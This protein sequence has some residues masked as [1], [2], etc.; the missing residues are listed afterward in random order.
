MEEV[1]RLINIRFILIAA[2]ILFTNAL[3]LIRDNYGQK[4]AAK[5]YDRLASLAQEYKSDDVTNR[6][7]VVM[8]YNQYKLENDITIENISEALQEARNLLIAEADYVDGYKGSVEKKIETSTKLIDA[9][10]YKRNSFENINILKTRYDM[11]KVKDINVTLSNGRWLDSLYDYSY[12]QIFSVILLSITV[13]GF[14]SE[15]KTGL[16]YIIHTGKNGRVRLFFKRFAII[17]VEALAVNII[18]YMEAVL[19][20]LNIYGGSGAINDLASSSE[21][22]FIVGGTYTRVQMAVI[23]MLVSTFTAIVLSLMLWLILSLFSNINIGMC[24]YVVLCA[25]FVIVHLL[26]STKSPV[27]FAHYLNLYYWFYPHKLIVY[28]NWGYSFGVTS[29]TASALVFTLVS[30]AVFLLINF[31]INTKKY[32]TGRANAVERTLELVMSG[33]MR[34]LVHAPQFLKEIYKIL[35]S[36]KVI[37]VLAVLMYFVIKTDV[38]GG[39]MYSAEMSYL[40]GYYD[41]AKG[42]SYSRQLEEIYHEYELEYEDFKSDLDENDEM[43]LNKIQ[44]RAYLLAKIRENVDYVK[45]LNEKGISAEVIKPYEYT[46]VFGAKQEENQKLLALI[47]VFAVIVISAGYLSYERKNEIEKMATSYA[48]RRVWLVKKLFANALLISIFFCISYGLYYYKLFS[49]YKIAGFSVHIKSL[50]MFAGYP[51][52]VTVAGMIIID[53]LARLTM[54]LCISG[55]ISFLSKYISYRYC[56]V[57]GLTI[58]FPQL[59]SMM[60]FEVFDRFSIGKYIAFFPCFNEGGANIRLFYIVMVFLCAAGILSC[61]NILRNRVKYQ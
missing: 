37:F 51:I 39:I 3:F 43:D 22:F 33:L 41:S 40:A 49:V 4:D 26:I 35:I 61:I 9:G 34:I 19:I 57:V 31:F 15:R 20:L 2:A 30:G 23:F 13:Y 6:E 53:S 58:A 28:H 1:K 60:G 50:P 12:M 56:L 25:V 54:L 55:I 17:S 18:L 29:L 45:E 42:V 10:I 32:F 46:E 11:S 48:K 52:N 38:G 44:Y 16:Y 36:Q 14:F 47:N 8:A 24:V 59:L 21:T 7:T 27:R 5:V